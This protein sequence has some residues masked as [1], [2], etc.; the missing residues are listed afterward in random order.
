MN[1]PAKGKNSIPF[2]RIVFTLLIIMLHCGYTQGGY[3]GVE[4]FF[5][6]SGFLL[7]KGYYGKKQTSIKQYIKKR[8][9]RLYPMYLVSIIIFIS[10]LSTLDFTSQT[11]SAR[12][13]FVNII[14][15]IAANWKSV[16][17]L[18]LFGNGPIVVNSPAWYVVALFWV[19]LVYFVLMKILPKKAFNVFVG[20]TSLAVLICC[21]VFVGHLDLWEEKTLYISQGIFRAY[22]EIGLGILLYSLKE[23]LDKRKKIS[24]A[25]IISCGS[26]YN[27]HRMRYRLQ[28]QF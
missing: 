24:T 19:A 23:V 26:Y 10:L 4:F 20:I 12:L 7:A 17:M 9:I 2:W 18:Q 28:D 13:Y 8:I 15:N 3:I 21:F 25:I 11:F 1:V 16:F 14:E 6:V 22:A 27:P 5:L